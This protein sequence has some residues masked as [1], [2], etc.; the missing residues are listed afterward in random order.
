MRSFFV[1]P[2]T[3]VYHTI[4]CI[5]YSSNATISRRK[6]PANHIN[7][8]RGLSNNVYFRGPKIF[9]PLELRT[10]SVVCG[11]RRHLRFAI[12]ISA[13]LRSRGHWPRSLAN[14]RS[15]TSLEKKNEL[16]R[17]RFSRRNRHVPC[18]LAIRVARR[19][20]RFRDRRS[21][22]LLLDHEVA[23]SGI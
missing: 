14:E 11:T 17:W 1:T 18:L 5:M 13:W 9:P 4:P 12:Y 22:C 6:S 10:I 3:A 19:C 7:K 23:C 21:L 8:S 15:Q 20:I 16:A 2:L